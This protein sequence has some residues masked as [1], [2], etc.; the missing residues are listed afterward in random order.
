[1]QLNRP[2]LERG[3]F[4]AV[5]SRKSCRYQGSLRTTLRAHAHYRRDHL[6]GQKD[7]LCGDVAVQQ[8]WLPARAFL[9]VI[10]EHFFFELFTPLLQ[11][12]IGP[13]A[14]AWLAT[15]LNK[16]PKA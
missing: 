13:M 11:Y 2:R 15:K 7:G 6:P 1:M 12:V 8:P 5:V 10:M 4:I 9:L 3:C 16:K 14:V